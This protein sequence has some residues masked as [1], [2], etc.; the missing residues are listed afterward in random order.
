MGEGFKNV[1][2]GLLFQIDPHLAEGILLFLQRVDQLDHLLGESLQHFTAQH[3]LLVALVVFVHQRLELLGEVHALDL[4]DLLEVLDG[5]FEQLLEQL[6]LGVGQFDLL[7]LG[8]VVVTEY[9][10]LGRAVFAEFEDLFDSVPL[11][12]I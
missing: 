12:C 9:V 10:D 11:Q 2:K 3:V 1:I 4:V 5:A 7:D 8:E 6:D